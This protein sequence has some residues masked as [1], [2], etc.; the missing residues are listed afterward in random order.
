[1]GGAHRDD[2][3]EV[4]GKPYNGAACHAC[5]TAKGSRRVNYQD[6]L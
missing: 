5:N 1:M 3:I 4:D 6:N 2:R